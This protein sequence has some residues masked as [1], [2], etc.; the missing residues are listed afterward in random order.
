MVL[1]W[2][3]PSIRRDL[4]PGTLTPRVGKSRLASATTAA[5][6]RKPVAA[7]PPGPQLAEVGER[8]GPVAWHPRRGAL[9]AIAEECDRAVFAAPGDHTRPHGRELLCLVDGDVADARQAVVTA[10]S[11]GPTWPASG[12][13]PR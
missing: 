6:T 11:S 9:G 1:M 5:G 2:G 7:V 8:R 13:S 10:G 12:A 3:A 4:A